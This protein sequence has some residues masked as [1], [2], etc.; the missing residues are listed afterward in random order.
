MYSELVSPNISIWA[1]GQS[2]IGRTYQPLKTLSNDSI[3][4]SCSVPEYSQSLD[5]EST[6]LLSSA[7]NMSSPNCLPTTVIAGQ[8]R[9]P[10]CEPGHHQIT[11]TPTA[12][13]TINP[14]QGRRNKTFVDPCEIAPLKKRRIQ[15]DMLNPDERDKVLQKREKNKVAAEKCRV[16]RREKMHN[17]RIEYEEYLESNEA[18]QSEVK[19]LQEERDR[20]DQLLKH[21][22][23]TQKV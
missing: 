12:T 5:L 1:P 22:H 9:Q 23:C 13:R 10:V 14:R 15:V 17:V 18:L 4:S 8:E 11:V 19:K 21:H 20:L 2:I 6:I 7:M 16:K 3:P